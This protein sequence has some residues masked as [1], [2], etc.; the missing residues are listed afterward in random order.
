MTIN[1][2]FNVR[3]SQTAEQWEAAQAERRA[4]A[5]ADHPAP[6]QQW[7]DVGQG[8]A[9][10]Q[11]VASTS[12]AATLADH[13]FLLAH[14]AEILAPHTH[15]THPAARTLTTRTPTRPANVTTTP[16]MSRTTQAREPT[17]A[18][19]QTVERR[20]IGT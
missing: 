12:T 18:S 19:G 8:M 11:P 17:A 2:E 13:D 3:N 14:T 5:L 6:E 15:R 4:A 10:R 9:G 1:P 16:A 20:V 7:G